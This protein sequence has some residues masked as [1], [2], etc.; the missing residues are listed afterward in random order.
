ITALV[1]Q[2][3]TNKSSVL[4]ALYGSPNNYSLGNLWFSTDLDEIKD[5]GRSRFIYGYYD[6][7]SKD[8]VEVIKTRIV[9]KEDPDLWETSRPL[10]KDGMKKIPT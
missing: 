2:N 4:R 9:D 5:G 7:A 1:G 10:T 8:V 3:G 6:S